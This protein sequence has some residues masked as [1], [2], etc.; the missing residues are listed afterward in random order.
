MPTGAAAATATAHTNKR[1]LGG[2]WSRTRLGHRNGLGREGAVDVSSHP[3]QLR[4]AARAVDERHLARTENRGAHDIHTYNEVFVNDI[5]PYPSQ[6]SCTNKRKKKH[7]NDKL[8]SPPETLMCTWRVR[9][10]NVCGGSI[11]APNHR[12]QQLMT[13]R[14]TFAQMEVCRIYVSPTKA[15]RSLPPM[16]RSI[17][18]FPPRFPRSRGDTLERLAVVV[19]GMQGASSHLLRLAW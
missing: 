6:T 10:P 12:Q 8:F 14:N 19:F 11:T 15:N 1:H 5:L 13:S 7:E 4:H 17:F 18:S 9:H 16:R 2:R 3:V